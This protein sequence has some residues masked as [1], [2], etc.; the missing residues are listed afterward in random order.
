MQMEEHAE[1]NSGI[2]FFMQLTREGCIAFKKTGILPIIW[3]Y[4]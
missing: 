4:I 3:T 1:G 2:I